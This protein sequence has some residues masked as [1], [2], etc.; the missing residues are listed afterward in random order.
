MALRHSKS[1]VNSFVYT[2]QSHPEN[3]FE[4]FI[5]LLSVDNG[6]ML[7]LAI[8]VINWKKFILLQ[9]QNFLYSI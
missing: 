6:S 7:G 3:Q 9:Y 2:F 8:Y 1:P 5:A 4:A